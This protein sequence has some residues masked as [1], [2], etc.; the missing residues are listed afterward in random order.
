MIMNVKVLDSKSHSGSHGS[1]D[2]RQEFMARSRTG[3][4]AKRIFKRSFLSGNAS[5]RTTILERVD[6][7]SIL[8]G[9]PHGGSLRGIPPR[10][11]LNQV[12]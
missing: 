11:H 4:H 1:L 10:P 6:L 8:I 2:K 5:C 9:R 7:V 12:H 3:K